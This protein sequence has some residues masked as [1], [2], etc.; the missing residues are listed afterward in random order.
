M[1]WKAVQLFLLLVVITSM[2]TAALWQ[3]LPNR[4][5]VLDADR[6]LIMVMEKR[7]NKLEM[8]DV[9]RNLRLPGDNMPDRLKEAFLAIEDRRF[10]YHF[11]IDP[12]SIVTNIVRGLQGRRMG[13]GS[14]I[15]QQLAKNLFLSSDRTIW[16]KLKEMV[17]AFKLEHYF[18]KDR[19]IE[20]YLNNVYFGD[21]TYGVETASRQFFSKRTPDLNI[22]EMA[23]L[24]GAVKGPNRYHIRRHPE[25]ADRRGRVVLQ[26]MVRSGYIEADEK[27][28]A[29]AVGIQKGSRKLQS[30]SYQWLRDWIV[31]DLLEQLGSYEGRIRVF[32]TLNTEY[33]TYAE[34]AIK[35]YLR[36]YKN[37]KTSQAALV[38]IAA[39]GAVRAMVGGANYSKSQLN[40]ALVSRQPA[41]AFKPFVFLAGLEAGLNEESIVEDGPITIDGWSPR[42]NDDKFLGMMTLTE[43]LTKSRNTVAA[44]LYQHVG[45]EAMADLMHRLGVYGEI[46][47]NPSMAL[48]TWEIPLLYLSNMYRTIA[49]GGARVEPYGFMGII[50]SLGNIISWRE[51]EEPEYAVG[52]EMAAQLN[53]M[54]Q[55]VVSKGTGKNAAFGDL[56]IAGKTGTSQG[57]RDALFVGYS[58]ILATGVW[59]GN[60]DNSPMDGVGGGSAPALIWR[61]FMANCHDS[62][63]E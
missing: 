27:E 44:A 56:S 63:Y 49:N 38:S 40:R 31:P 54:L 43:A 32:T 19:I 39:D 16:R 42:N 3:F 62:L 58:D 2:L 17:L 59:M 6:G 33:Q 28:L 55:R 11:G 9:A 14:T 46:P 24:A 4:Q 52:M 15:T 48:G 10:N 50:D 35:R 23:L 22:Y 7:G 20:M 30:I 26:A 29:L 13:G 53:K 61:Y 57:N 21:N 51:P 8:V 5:Q 47:E 1:L 25:A 45:H 60:D 12:I 37:K 18:T 34:I 36:H 41:S